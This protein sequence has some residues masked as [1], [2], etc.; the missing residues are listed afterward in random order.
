ML[1]RPDDL[2]QPAPTLRLAARFAPRH[3]TPRLFFAICAHLFKSYRLSQPIT[4][5]RHF[6]QTD[7]KQVRLPGNSVQSAALTLLNVPYRS[8]TGNPP[9][10]PLMTDEAR[11]SSPYR[12]SCSETPNL[13][14]GSIVATKQGPHNQG[15]LLTFHRGKAPLPWDS[16]HHL[17]I[18]RIEKGLQVI[19]F[20]DANG[21]CKHAPRRPGDQDG[22]L[23]KRPTWC[24]LCTMLILS[25]FD[26]VETS[27]A[28]PWQEGRPLSCPLIQP[29]QLH[30]IKRSVP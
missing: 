10:L 11:P 27:R 18:Q 4:G 7:R 6:L 30:K 14:H 23:A 15:N 3:P 21:S 24:S 9:A 5:N 8:D 12:S 22:V 2:H 16:Y 13:Y 28:Q 26:R 19:R 25:F 17:P 1:Q 29:S 20:M